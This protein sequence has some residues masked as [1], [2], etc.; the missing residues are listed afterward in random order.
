MDNKTKQ[1]T[2]SNPLEHI[3]S[4]ESFDAH[5]VD[6]PPEL[7]AQQ[8]QVSRMH[9]KNNQELLEE[10][11]RILWKYEHSSFYSKS[12]RRARKQGYSC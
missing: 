8:I 1:Q 9:V 3:V 2:D 7:M 6:V 10:S 12:L 5:E 11:K 4:S